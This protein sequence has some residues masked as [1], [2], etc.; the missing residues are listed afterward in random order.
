MTFARPEAD[1]LV[2]DDILYVSFISRSM[3]A[4]IARGMRVEIGL[5]GGAATVEVHPRVFA[6]R[7]DAGEAHGADLA[8]L[9]NGLES[10]AGIAPL[11]D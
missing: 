4:V 5:G 7:N 11:V 2:I 8:A 9:E 1:S 10:V 3:A 6:I